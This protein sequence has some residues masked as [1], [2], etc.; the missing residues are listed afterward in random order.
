MGTF[1]T[2]IS[3]IV[4]LLGTSL[5]GLLNHA[6]GLKAAAKIW[7]IEFQNKQAAPIRRLAF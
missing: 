1:K 6:R 4:N 7:L 3:F 5:E 2:V